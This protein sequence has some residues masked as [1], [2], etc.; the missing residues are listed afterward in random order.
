MHVDIEM[1]NACEND[2]V[3]I[4][5]G[6]DATGTPRLTMCGTTIPV[7]VTSF[8]SMLTVR[9][10][11]DSSI[12]RGGFQASYSE[13]G[14]GRFSAVL[15]SNHHHHHHHRILFVN[16]WRQTIGSKTNTGR[17][18]S[19]RPSELAAYNHSVAR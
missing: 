3:K 18:K 9:F 16:A 2:H 6:Q 17:Q 7:P 1:S 14:S 13:S 5:D 10:A 12:E 19:L 15:F 4:Y 11:S 8:G